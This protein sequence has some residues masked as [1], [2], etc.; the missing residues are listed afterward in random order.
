[1]ILYRD[2]RVK[3]LLT[4][5]VTSSFTPV[6]TS[7]CRMKG[8]I[9]S[10]PVLLYLK[11]KHGLC[12]RNNVRCHSQLF[13][14]YRV[15]VSKFAWKFYRKSAGRVTPVRNCCKA[16]EWVASIIIHK[17]PNNLRKFLNMKFRC[18]AKFNFA[19][20]FWLMWSSNTF[21]GFFVYNPNINN[22]FTCITFFLY[23][24]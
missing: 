3:W 17:Q 18:S 15:R 10:S 16:W 20:E 24:R 5:I 13:T 14:R 1:M 11:K 23:Y 22:T 2:V 21:N 4:D 6:I 9:M 7:T 19:I 12:A 8:Y